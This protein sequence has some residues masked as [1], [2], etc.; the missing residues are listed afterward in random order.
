MSLNVKDCF[1]KPTSEYKDPGCMVAIVIWK[2]GGRVALA[3]RVE[4]GA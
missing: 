4:L 2:F 1:A 3:A